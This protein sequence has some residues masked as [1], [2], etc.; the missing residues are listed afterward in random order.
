MDKR[1]W[2]VHCLSSVTDRSAGQFAEEVGFVHAVLE[3]FAAVDEDYGDFVGEL[4]AELIVAV[5]VD[6][7]PVEAAAA[8]EFGEVFFHDF[9]QVASFAGVEH[10]VA[11]GGHRGE[12]SNCDGF[13]PVGFTPL[14]S[15]TRRD[16]RGRL[17]PRDHRRYNPT[18]ASDI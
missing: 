1:C 5:Y 6:V 9:A 7:L 18:Y 3:G 12:F 2:H 13:V 17:S 11:K 10:D 15:F 16:S 8:R 14:P 4:A